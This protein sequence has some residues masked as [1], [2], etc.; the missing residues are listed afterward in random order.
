MPSETF[1]NLP[2]QKRE[3]LVA[4]AVREFTEKPFNE[5]SINCIVKNAGISRGS[6]YMYFQD[7]EDLLRYLMQGYVEGLMQVAEECLACRSGDM[8]AAIL[9][10]YDYLQIHRN[11]EAGM[12]LICGMVNRNDG[13]QKRGLLEFLE[14]ENLLRKLPKNIDPTL[15]DLKNEE[16]FQDCVSILMGLGIPMFYA[17]LRPGYEQETRKRLENMLCILRRGMGAKTAEVEVEA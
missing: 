3:K 5:A 9:D 17:G 1:L 8:F 4:A 12:Q 15:L 16:D 14:P 11:D 2:Q 10:L 13:A 6:F 7:K